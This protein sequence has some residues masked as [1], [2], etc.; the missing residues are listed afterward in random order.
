MSNVIMM[1]QLGL[2]MT[3]GTVGTW[4]KKPGDRVEKD[5]II[6]AVMTDKV[7]MDV[8]STVSGVIREI[9]VAEGETVPVQYSP[10]SKVQ[11]HH[12]RNPNLSRRRQRNR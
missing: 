7:D 2:T 10:T 3:E 6:V 11:R 1:P 12:L 5:E 4:L 8:E 9:V